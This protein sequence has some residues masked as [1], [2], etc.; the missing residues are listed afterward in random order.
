MLIADCHGKC[1]PPDEAERVANARLIAAAPKLLED[2]FAASS[3]LK[4]HH[5]T[6]P[7]TKN[8]CAMLDRTIHEATHEDPV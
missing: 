1:S 2:L 3:F 7:R 8:F 4:Y 5:G 6:D